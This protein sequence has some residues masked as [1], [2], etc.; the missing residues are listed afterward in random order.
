VVHSICLTIPVADSSPRTPL[1][2]KQGMLPLTFVD[3][4]DY[5]KISPFDKIKLKGLTVTIP[6]LSLSQFLHCL[7][8]FSV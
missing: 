3:P 7:P 4:A 2:R 8:F 6:R 1:H 5:D